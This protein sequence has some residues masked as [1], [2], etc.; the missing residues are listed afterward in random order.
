MG[1]ASRNRIA[2]LHGEVSL[3]RETA[4]SESSQSVSVSGHVSNIDVFSWDIDEPVRDML[5]RAVFV[6][7]NDV[8]LDDMDVHSCADGSRVRILHF[9]DDEIVP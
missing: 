7:E 1:V 6:P 3:E 8:F 2:F 9:A 4:L 5:G